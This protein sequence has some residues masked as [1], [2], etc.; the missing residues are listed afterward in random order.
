MAE[1]FIEW[2]GGPMPVKDGTPLVTRHRHGK[3]DKHSLAGEGYATRWSHTGEVDD[4]VAYR[5]D[6][7]MPTVATSV[8]A[9]EEPVLLA[10]AEYDED[11]GIYLKT[12]AI[13][14]GIDFAAARRAVR[15]LAR[16]GLAKL[17]RGLMS[18]DD[19]L[20]R[21]SGYQLTREGRALAAKIRADDAAPAA[22]LEG[23]K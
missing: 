15:A 21:G 14:A 11:Y 1:K 13:D 18:E 5:L 16:K 23:S 22:A 12:I 10:L 17:L 20:L 2:I 19:G 9:R 3:G 8:T 4:I 7:Q 6:K